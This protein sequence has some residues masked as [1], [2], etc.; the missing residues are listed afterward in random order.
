MKTRIALIP[1]YEPDE[2]LLSIT[3]QLLESGFIVVV[4]NDGSNGS[5]DG[6]FKQ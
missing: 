1:S 4:V 5:Y 3:K 6:I 2:A